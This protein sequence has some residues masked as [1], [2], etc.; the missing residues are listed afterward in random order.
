VSR[1]RSAN[2]LNTSQI[3]VGQVLTIPSAIDI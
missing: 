2:R 1:I 3:K